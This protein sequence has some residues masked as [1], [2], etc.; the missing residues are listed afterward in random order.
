MGYRNRWVHDQP[1]TIEGLGNVY[2]RRNRWV[3]SE[4]GTTSK[5]GLGSGDDAEYSIDE[6]YN[7]VEP[8]VFHFVELFKEIFQYYI[9]LI[10]EQGISIS[11]KGISSKIV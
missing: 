11:D 1:P 4:D 8:A 6:I 5:L 3:T 2:E 7:F 9:D 10:S